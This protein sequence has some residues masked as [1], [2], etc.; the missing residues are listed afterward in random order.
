MI[1]ENCASHPQSSRRDE[2]LIAVVTQQHPDGRRGLDDAVIDVLLEE[3]TERGW[4]LMDLS[5]TAGSLDEDVPA[6]AL[7]TALPDDPLVV[8]LLSYDCPIIRLGRLPHPDDSVVPAVFPDYKAAGIMAADYFAERGFRDVALV[9][10]EQ[11]MMVHMIE[12]AFCHRS[13]Q[14][15]REC[16]TYF[17][18]N[19]NMLTEINENPVSRYDRRTRQIAQWLGQLPNPLGLLTTGDV[20]G[21]MMYMM[22]A[23]AGLAVPE[24][25]AILSLG[26]SRASCELCPVPISAV[27]MSRQDLARTAVELLANAM[28]GKSPPSQTLVPPR[29]VETRRSTDIMAV[30][31]PLVARAVRYIWDHVDVKLSVDDVAKGVDVPRYRIE[32]LFKDHLGRGVNA[33]LRRVRIERF[34]ELL[35]TTDKTVEQLAPLVGYRSATRLHGVFR[36]KFGITPRQYRLQVQAQE[37]PDNAMA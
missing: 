34:R 18:K 17:F 2:R 36:D 9:G 11:M 3:A 5:L 24:D 33:E 1:Q 35:K 12:Q 27:D 26:N 31:H 32:R 25:V 6:G 22:C 19:P 16:H 20:I 8:N 28:D 23:R 13:Q 7:V 10:H 37:S 29:G 14:L 4:R 21:N 15:D 30:S